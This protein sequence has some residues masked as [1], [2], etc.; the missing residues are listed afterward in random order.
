MLTRI[1]RLFSKRRTQ[2]LAGVLLIALAG[3]AAVFTQRATAAR[4]EPWPRFTMVYQ[5]LRVTNSAGASVT[6]TFRL[7]YVD[8]RHFTNTLLANSAVPEAAG[9]THTVNGTSSTTTDPRMGPV[10]SAVWSPEDVTLPDDWLRPSRTPWLAH[11]PGA[12]VTPLPGNLFQVRIVSNLEGR[13]DI[14]ELTFRPDGIP[15]RYLETVDGKEVRRVEV[16]D[17]MLN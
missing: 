15:T 3:G 2:I 14:E 1:G 9:W 16:L 8:S 7:T 12:V 5:D 4:P 17:L 10:S 6:Q 11:R 13:V